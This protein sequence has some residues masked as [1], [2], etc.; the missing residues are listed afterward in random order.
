M[1]TLVWRPLGY[2]LAGYP[3][4]TTRSCVAQAAAL[5]AGLGAKSSPDAYAAAIGCDLESPGFRHDFVVTGPAP[6]DWRTSSCGLFARSLLRHL[7]CGSAALKS[8]YA[9]G[10]A[11]SALERAARDAGVW[12]S[13]SLPQVGCII[14]YGPRL[15]AASGQHVSVVT[16]VSGGVTTE[17]A[18]GASG[19]WGGG[20]ETAF[21]KRVLAVDG[22]KLIA[23][24][25]SGKRIV[26]GWID[27]ALMP[28]TLEASLPERDQLVEPVLV[29]PATKPG[30][31]A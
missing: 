12:R 7:G 21:A 4:E 31:I 24:S 10:S 9:T 29:P 30:L 17:V 16:D 8:P 1:T 2:T 22:G 11:I 23:S 25:D 28:W 3:P 6:S 18:G 15:G 19:G 13:G 27:T 26:V 14:M 20:T 5:L